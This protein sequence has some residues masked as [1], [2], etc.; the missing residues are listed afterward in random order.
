MPFFLDNW[1][2]AGNSIIRPMA[3]ILAVE[4]ANYM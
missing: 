1:V 2:R 4:H 3:E